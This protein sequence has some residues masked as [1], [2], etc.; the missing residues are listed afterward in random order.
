MAEVIDLRLT[1]QDSTLLVV[2]S[3]D[4]GKALTFLL[5]NSGNG[6]ETF[7]LVCNNALAG[8]QFDPVS[9]AAGAI[10]LESDRREQFTAIPVVIDNEDAA[11][12]CL[13]ID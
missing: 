7:K 4:L 13:D 10:Y 11:A 8:D 1:W 2:N 12:W 9:A 6:P 5:T 3:P